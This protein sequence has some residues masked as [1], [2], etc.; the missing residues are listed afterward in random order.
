MQI[1]L[2]A[3]ANFVETLDCD[4]QFEDDAFSFTFHDV[5][6]YCERKRRH[7]NL[8]IGAELLQMPR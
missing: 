6:V 7:F 3:L 4:A 5:R 2:N 8:H 1:D